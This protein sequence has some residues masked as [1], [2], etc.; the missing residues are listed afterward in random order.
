MKYQAFFLREI[1]YVVSSNVR[2][3]KKVQNYWSNCRR[4][5]LT[6]TIQTK[7]RKEINQNRTLPL[8]FN[9]DVNIGF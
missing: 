2:V 6:Q 9:T 5:N 4:N 8:E 3:K 1:K 7:T